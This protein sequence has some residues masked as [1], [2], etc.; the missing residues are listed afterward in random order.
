MTT[1][2]KV[3][4]IQKIVN[5]TV[6]GIFGRDTQK[7]VA[8][9]L[10]C[11]NNFMHIQK[12][13]GT[14]S[15]GILGPKT[16]DAILAALS[17]IDKGS[18]IVDEPKTTEKIKIALLPGH[19]SKDGGAEMVSG[20]KLSE[21]NFAMKFIPEVKQ[22]LEQMGYEVV[23]TRREDAGGTTPSYSAKAANATNADAAFEFH[24]NSAGS[25]ATGSEYLYEACSSKYK[26]AASIMGSTW[27]KLTGIK[28]RGAL[29]VCTIEE[30]H[31]YKRSTSR[32]L[33][34]FKKANMFF[35]MTEP[36][37]SS[38]PKE[39]EYVTELYKSG[40]WSKYMA[41]AIA[42]ACISLFS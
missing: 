26:K 30:Q 3:K 31:K 13:V 39:C 42:N 17:S 38:N 9:Y 21:Y 1:K 33:N 8:S 23:V 37:F 36:F 28:D 2:D 5:V 35:C 10:N 40:Q 4:E 16:A 24:F 11:E 19:S 7:A 18:T 12:R 15:D 25:Q 32:G 41:T 29:P 34:A 22:H 27:S 14:K 6:D 20:L